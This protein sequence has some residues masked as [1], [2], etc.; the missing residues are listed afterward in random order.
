MLLRKRA[1]YNVLIGI[2][3]FISRHSVVFVISGNR[4]F[5]LGL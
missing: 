1:M 2:L 5:L 4:K 3:Q